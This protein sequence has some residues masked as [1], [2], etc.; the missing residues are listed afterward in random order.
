MSN[1]SIINK[2]HALYQECVNC[3]NT[4]KECPGIWRDSAKGIIPDGFYF[5][6]VPVDVL[7]V[8]KNTGHPDERELKIFP[9]LTGDTLYK[10]LRAKQEVDFH[11][12]GLSGSAQL[13]SR[14]LT[15]YLHSILDIEEKDLFTR[16]AFTNLVKCRTIVESGNKLHKNTMKNCFDKYL[17]KAV[18]LLRPKVILALGREAEV[19]LLRKSWRPLGVPV[20][21]LK[22]T[23]RPLNKKDKS[24]ILDEL[25]D[26]IN[27]FINKAKG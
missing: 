5:E 27:F 14:K 4:E 16:I 23:S 12:G 10:T 21:Y 18:S 3:P 2:L 11:N 25:K 24:G 20:L 26:D 22:H 19:F 7:V 8:G 1:Q 13:L 17:K 9:G 15:E 6:T